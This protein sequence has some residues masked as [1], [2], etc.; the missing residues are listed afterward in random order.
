MKKNITSFQIGV[1]IFFMCFG[2]Y[3]GIANVSLFSS[4]EQDAWLSFLFSILLSL[5]PIIFTIF[6]INY[7]PDKN[8]IEKNQKLFGKYLGYIINFILCIYIFML[9]I[10]TCWNLF[11]FVKIEFLNNTPQIFIGIL[12]LIAA[13]YANTKGVETILK[14]G[15]IILYISLF[16]I[17][18]IF[19]SLFGLINLNNLKPVL[20]HG[21]NPVIYESLR[22]L[23]YTIIPSF[24]ITIIPKNYVIDN[25]NLTK[26]ILRSYIIS[27][28]LLFLITFIIITVLGP[29]LAT[30]YQFPAYYAVRKINIIGVIENTENFFSI[31]WI[32]SM[33]FI[34]TMCL[35]YIKIYIREIF[36]IKNK[37]IENYIFILIILFTL[38]YSDKVFPSTI[39]S[40]NFMTKS[41]NY[42]IAF[43]IFIIMLLLTFTIFITKKK[44]LSNNNPIEYSNNN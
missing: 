4:T 20:S 27:Q 31:L 12:F 19:L 40:I 21:F 43:V 10:L 3:E 38:Y 41:Y 25:K 39:N 28:F 26:V 22:L 8:I 30:I 14:S 6:I 42:F 13:F 32:Y 2:L 16:F 29:E 24:I 44:L 15:E 7:E 18:I 11:S 9:L 17:V 33:Y 1:L 35:Y 36:K 34:I 5:I 23:S 37:K